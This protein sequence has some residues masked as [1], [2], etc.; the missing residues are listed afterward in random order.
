ML[1]PSLLS[2]FRSETLEIHLAFPVF[3]NVNQSVLQYESVNNSVLLSV[4][5]SVG[6][7]VRPSISPPFSGSVCPPVC[8]ST[9][10]MVNVSV[11]LSAYHSLG[12]CVCPLSFNGAVCLQIC[13]PTMH[14]VSVSPRLSVY[15][16][17]GKY[18]YTGMLSVYHSV[19][20]SARPAVCLPFIGSV[21]LPNCLPTIYALSKCV[22]PS[23]SLFTR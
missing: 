11:H 14:L 2:V 18:V 19:G 20:Q 1:D 22:F 8:L 7:Y 10:Q 3:P 15:H 21:Y 17:L 23:V 4:H 5:Y 9:V 6:Q 12:R 13:L 16:L